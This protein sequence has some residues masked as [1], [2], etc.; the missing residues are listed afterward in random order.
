MVLVHVEILGHNSHKS[1]G[2]QPPVTPKEEK[3]MES[4]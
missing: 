1:N 4:E 2:P 3:Y